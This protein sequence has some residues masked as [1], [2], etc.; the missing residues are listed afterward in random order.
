[1]SIP[2]QGRKCDEVSASP[3]GK[4]RLEVWSRHRPL[5]CIG[6]GG[7][8]EVL[9]IEN[10]S[11]RIVG[12]MPTTSVQVVFGMVEWGPHQVEFDVDSN[13]RTYLGT[14]THLAY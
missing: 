5:G 12:K 4:Y 13:E 2:A 11:E 1:M 3:D 8:G 6:N 9:L 7:P 14:R 10:G